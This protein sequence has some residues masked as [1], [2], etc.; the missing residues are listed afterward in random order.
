MGLEANYK[1]I[2]YISWQNTCTPEGKDGLSIKNLKMWN[3]ASIA[4]LVW[5]LGIKKDLLWV[6]CIHE[7]YP[8]GKNS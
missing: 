3:D 7:I 2:R 4:K 6:K 8:R 1:R 5:S